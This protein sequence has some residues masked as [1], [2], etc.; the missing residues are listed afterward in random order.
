MTLT[1]RDFGKVA[2]TA[3]P[4]AGLG[5]AVRAADLRQ[6][7]RPNSKVAGVQ[8]GLNVPYN[9]GSR[10]MEGGQILERCIGLNVNAVELRSQPVEIFLGSPA[11]HPDGSSTLGRGATPDA[12]RAQAE[13]VRAWR[14][15][16]DMDDVARFRQTWNDAGV[17]I[18]IVKFDGIYDLSDDEVDYSFRLAKALG[19][20][21][22][23]AEIA[24]D[25]LSRTR[26]IGEYADRHGIMVGY[27]GH[28]E[29]TPEHWETTFAYAKHNGANLDLGHFVAGHSTSPIPFLREHH[30]RITHV[31]VKDRKMNHGPNVP[32]GQG[33]TPIVEALQLIRDNG[34]NIQATIEFEYPIPEGSDRMTEMAKAIDYCRKALEA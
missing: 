30:D 1:R 20:R 18:E 9:F 17:L 27:H 22:I 34:W 12:Q 23:S 15:R 8:I 2:L 3:L 13:A 6:V 29:T 25:D 24:L 5:R 33:D 4:L 28:E 21:A 14:A 11:F 32:F 7:V 16:V 31:H 10:T 26:R 19:A